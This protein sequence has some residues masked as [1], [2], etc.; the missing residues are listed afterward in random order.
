MH[1]RM[2][3]LVVAAAG[4]RYTTFEAQ[5]LLLG[6]KRS[7]ECYVRIDGV[8]GPGGMVHI[9]RLNELAAL[10]HSIGVLPSS[11]VPALSSAV[12]ARLQAAAQAA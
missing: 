10:A 6:A 1:W 5:L 4:G 2:E 11:F 3:N 8:I 7:A 9:N 12:S